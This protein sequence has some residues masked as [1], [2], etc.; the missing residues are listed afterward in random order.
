MMSL[1]TAGYEKKLVLISL[2]DLIRSTIVLCNDPHWTHH[3]ELA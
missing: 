1:A 3:L 2:V